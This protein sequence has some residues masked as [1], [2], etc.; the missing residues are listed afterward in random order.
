MVYTLGMDMAYLKTFI[1]LNRCY[2]A[3]HQG[4]SIADHLEGEI[5][6]SEFEV[7]EALL[8]KG[9]L[10]QQEISKKVLKSK[11][12]ISL[13]IDALDRKGLIR[14]ERCASDRRQVLCS[15]SDSGRRIIERA[16]PRVRDSIV[17]LFSCLSTEENQELARL[18]KK[19]GL[20]SQQ[21]GG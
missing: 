3:V 21:G 9:E 16:F 10:H 12:N 8:H 7:L 6:P 11:G 15:L 13:V 4:L 1:K 14:R 18:L 17:E 2:D 19:L 20:R 5:T